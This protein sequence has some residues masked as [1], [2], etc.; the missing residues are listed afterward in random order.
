MFAAEKEMAMSSSSKPFKA[1][2]FED[3]TVSVVRTDVQ[4]P[5]LMEIIAIFYDA[6]RAREYA[7]FENAR[8]PE[9]PGAAPLAAPKGGSAIPEE[10]ATE[11]SGRQ[12][13]VLL[14]L[15]TK[16]DENKLVEAKAADLAKAANIPLGSL[17]S[18]LQSL[19][20]KRRIQ[21][22]R[23]GSPRAPAVYQVL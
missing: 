5:N 13:A 17:H 15:R 4:N 21:T 8:T 22:R 14:A 20:K 12:K 23:A 6:S 18:V 16:M 3:G 1:V 9:Q 10:G 19:E 7:D 11:L 2:A